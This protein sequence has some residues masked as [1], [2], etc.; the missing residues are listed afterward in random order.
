[1]SFDGLIIIHFFSVLSNI[2]L[3]KYTIVCLLSHL[4]NDYFQALVIVNKVVNIYIQ[5]LECM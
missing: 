2:S 4:L 5:V 1:M 3:H